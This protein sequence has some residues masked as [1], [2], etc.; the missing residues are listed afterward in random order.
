MDL[1]S[2]LQQCPGEG[3]QSRPNF[4]NPITGAHRSKRN[5]LSDNVSV[6][7]EILSQAPPRAVAK[8]AK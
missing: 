5:A 4:Q 1:S 8:G 3:P 2:G 6:D 7:E